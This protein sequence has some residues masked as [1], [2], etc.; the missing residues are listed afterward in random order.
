M[1]DEDWDDLDS[2]S[3][4]TILLCLDHLRGDNNSFMEHNRESVYDKVIDE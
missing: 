2:R 4:S 3:L 1:S